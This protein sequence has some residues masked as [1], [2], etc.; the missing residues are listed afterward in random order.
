MREPVTSHEQ[1]PPYWQ[2]YREK[3]RECFRHI[4]APSPKITM[5]EAGVSTL[6][7]KRKARRRASVRAHKSDAIQ[8]LSVVIEGTAF[9]CLDAYQLQFLNNYEFGPT[10]DIFFHH[11]ML[12]VQLGQFHQSHQ[13]ALQSGFIRTIEVSKN[14]ALK[15]PYA[16]GLKILAAAREQLS[17]FSG[18]REKVTRSS[19]QPPEKSGRLPERDERSPQGSIAG[20]YAPNA[21]RGSVRVGIS[22]HLT[23]AR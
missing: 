21:E 13:S 6:R 3:R 1:L 8:T 23:E 11:A 12:A 7:H 5:C 10:I 19:P 20:T 4:P 2:A 18:P 14:Q 9:P 22:T 17:R 16:T 15:Q